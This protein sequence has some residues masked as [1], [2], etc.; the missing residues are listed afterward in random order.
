ML[1]SHPHPTLHLVV[2]MALIASWP[3]L[4][5]PR[6]MV[7]D[8]SLSGCVTMASWIKENAGLLSSSKAIP[9][10]AS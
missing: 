6:D 9:L 7:I 4:L 1:L 3:F 10:K 5:A 2:G 8:P